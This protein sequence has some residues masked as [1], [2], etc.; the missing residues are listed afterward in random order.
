[1]SPALNNV[2]R[3]LLVVVAA[4]ACGGKDG[5]RGDGSNSGGTP[6]ILTLDS[7]DSLT[8]PLTDS[9]SSGGYSEGDGTVGVDASSGGSDSAPGEAGE[10]GG[11]KFDLGVMPD[12]GEV[13]SGDIDCA[14]DPMNP[15]CMCT[16]PDHVA[17]DNGVTDPFKAMGLNCPGEPQVN[18]VAA[19]D[20]GAIGVRS[21]FGLGGVFNAR[22]GS[23]SA[24]IGSGLVADLNFVTPQGD[25]DGG[26]THC[27]DI[28]GGSPDP[29]PNLPAPIKIN[30]AGGD[31]T[32]GQGVGSGDCSGT[33]QGQFDQGGN[34][35]DYTELRFTLQVP[36]DVTSFSY[37]FAF[38]S[39]EYPYYF[40]SPF[41]DM[42]IGWLESEKW[43]G[44]ISFDQN[45]NPISL[46]AGF[47]EFKDDN[48]NTPAL[49]GTCMRQHAGTNWLTTT[50]GVTPG[51]TITVVFAIFD[52][53]DPILD[54]YAFID[55]FKWGCEPTGKPQTMPPA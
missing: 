13:D 5:D 52:L 21:N 36:P 28:L 27:N 39:V 53:S 48:G 23:Q 54:S 8:G 18:A 38:F 15:D 6:G 4:G 55:N 25:D 37:D 11:P 12:G 24:V 31:C 2:F 17:C 3:G 14:A 46:N 43:T 51:E 42:Y 26:P 29:G 32:M 9:A 50:A 10:D 30:R 45:G 33:I 22:E 44:N 20:G 34:A 19:G 47:L 49:A 1:M 35:Y 7:G 16:I 41:N 40:G